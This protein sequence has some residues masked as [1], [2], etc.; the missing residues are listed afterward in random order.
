MQSWSRVRVAKCQLLVTSSF[1]LVTGW[2]GG[3]G[4]GR[5][6]LSDLQDCGSPT[7]SPAVPILPLGHALG[8]PGGGLLAGDCGDR[9]P[10]GA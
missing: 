3:K 1:V 6:A 10:L 7:P 2:S 9:T 4:G 8:A 5:D